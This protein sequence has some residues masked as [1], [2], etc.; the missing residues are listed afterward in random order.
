M[1]ATA[2]PGRCCSAVLISGAVYMSICELLA[3]LWADLAA[4]S[5]SRASSS[6]PSRLAPCPPFLSISHLP[7]RIYL[8][9]Y[10]PPSHHPSHPSAILPRHRHSH[11]PTAKAH[12]PPTRDAKASARRGHH[13]T[14]RVWAG[15]RA[16][17]ARPRYRGPASLSTPHIL[18]VRGRKRS[19][20]PA[21][22]LGICS[23]KYT[24]RSGA[25][26]ILIYRTP[27][28]IRAVI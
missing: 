17:L 9:G 14:L 19:I 1:L 10:L 5:P 15:S 2:P 6:P 3:T 24:V 21:R 16:V 12:M 26:H 8:S 20:S 23:G 7:S 4:T 25:V 13:Y 28:L 22:E 11:L 27:G 18:L